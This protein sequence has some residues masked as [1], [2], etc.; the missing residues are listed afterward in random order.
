MLLAQL[1]KVN[2]ISSPKKK[3]TIKTSISHYVAFT[4]TMVNSIDIKPLL[5]MNF[6]CLESINGKHNIK[7][8]KTLY[9]SMP[10]QSFPPKLNET[11]LFLEEIIYWA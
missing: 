1:P 4:N 3:K 2:Y 6:C 11:S 10:V 8:V 9:P 5:K 7:K